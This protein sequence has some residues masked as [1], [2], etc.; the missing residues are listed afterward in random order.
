MGNFDL[1]RRS[2]LDV[3]R[4]M[5]GRKLMRVEK[6]IRPKTTGGYSSNHNF[7]NDRTFR[8][9]YVKILGDLRRTEF[10]NGKSLLETTREGVTLN[11]RS[12]QKTSFF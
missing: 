10:T 3:A 5:D 7:D 2:R 12:L 11:G 9:R 8:K 4:D 6:Q 1:K